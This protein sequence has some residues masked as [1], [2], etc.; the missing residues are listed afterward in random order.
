M[1]AWSIITA[2]VSGRSADAMII[3]RNL[4]K[5]GVFGSVFAALCC[6]GIPALLSILS[7]VGIGFVINDAILLPLFVIFLAITIAGLFS[8]MRHHGSPWA[9]TIGAVSSLIVV[10]FLFVRFNQ[11]LVVVGIGG[12]VFASTLNVL[13]Q[14][15]RERA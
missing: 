4:D 7:A 15:Q 2:V 8:G 3:S 10:G 5:V 11:A 12:L 14:R 13:L 1:R 6:L 9:L